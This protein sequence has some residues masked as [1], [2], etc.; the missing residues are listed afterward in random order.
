MASSSFSS[1]VSVPRLLLPPSA[2]VEKYIAMDWSP[3]QIAGHLKRKY[4]D[5]PRMRV[6]HETIYKSLYLQGRGALRKQLTQHLRTQRTKLLS[7]ARSAQV[8]KPGRIPNMVSFA[9]RP[10]E[11]EDRR[12]PGHWEGDLIIGKA[13]ASRIG[14]LV[15]RSTRFV[16]LLHLP[17]GRA[18]AEASVHMFWPSRGECIERLHG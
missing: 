16:M 9:D 4:P 7:K 5:N 8:E 14:T 3:Q 1:V 2:R 10:P 12:V 15:E 6:S 13:G 11:V 18:I 17:D